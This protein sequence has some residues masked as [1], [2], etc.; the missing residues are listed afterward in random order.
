MRRRNVALDDG[1]SWF[2]SESFGSKGPTVEFLP[3]VDTH[4]IFMFFEFT[5]YVLVAV[6]VVF[7]L[8]GA[9][10]WWKRNQNGR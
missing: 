10:E 6:A 3:A 5:W 4:V 7:L 2:L 9:W 8:L 1:I